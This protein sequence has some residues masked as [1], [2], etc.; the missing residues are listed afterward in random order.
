[1]ADADIISAQSGHYQVFHIAIV[2]CQGA[3]RMAW[4]VAICRSRPRYSEPP[5]TRAAD[6]APRALNIGAS[7]S[8]LSPC[9]AHEL[10][11]GCRIRLERQAQAMVATLAGFVSMAVH[12]CPTITPP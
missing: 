11:V 7:I 4:A 1:M 8:E 12:F 2:W 9:L 3:S 6:S 10:A 5:L